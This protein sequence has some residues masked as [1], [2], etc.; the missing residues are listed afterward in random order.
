M[1]S[2]KKSIQ[3]ESDHRKLSPDQLSGQSQF[4]FLLQLS[5]LRT[6]YCCNLSVSAVLWGKDIIHSQCFVLKIISKIMCIT[7]YRST[8]TQNNTANMFHINGIFMFFAKV[9]SKTPTALHTVRCSS[10]IPEYS[11]GIL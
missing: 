9:P 5:C 3:T 1:E 10:I 6:V 11:I 8:E 4:P 7:S 2:V